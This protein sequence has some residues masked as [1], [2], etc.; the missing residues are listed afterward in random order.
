MTLKFSYSTIRSGLDW[1]YRIQDDQDNR[2][3]TCYLE[4]NAKLVVDL[5]NEA[6]ERR[7]NDGNGSDTGG[8]KAITS[9]AAGAEGE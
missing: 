6:I 9:G 4:E 2:I 7:T 8:V 1:N 3:A 5:M